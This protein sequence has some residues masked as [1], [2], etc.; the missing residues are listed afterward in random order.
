MSSLSLSGFHNA[1]IAFLHAAPRWQQCVTLEL[2]LPNKCSALTM[3][4]LLS[5][6][7]L[8]AGL[9]WGFLHSVLRRLCSVSSS[10]SD[11]I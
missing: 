5:H 8:I 2:Q 1:A 6:D 3:S 9:D 10:G 7:Y 11:P 4:C